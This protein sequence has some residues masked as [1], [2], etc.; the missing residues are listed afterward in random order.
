[1]KRT[2]LMTCISIIVL[3]CSMSCTRSKNRNTETSAKDNSAESSQAF[4]Y[5]NK[6]EE[7]RIS[8]ATTTG[9]GLSQGLLTNEQKMF[10]EQKILDQLKFAASLEKEIFKVILPE[11]QQRLSQFEVLSYALEQFLNVKSGQLVGYECQKLNLTQNG[12]Q[13]FSFKSFCFKEPKTLAEIVFQSGGNHSFTVRFFTKEWQSV[14][15][16][17]AQLVGGDRECVFK[18]E[19]KTIVR[20]TCDHTV[21]NIN[22]SSQ[23]VSLQDIRIKTFEYSRNDQQEVRL[24]GGLY[25]DMIEIKKIKLTIP[26]IGKIKYE[27]K[28]LKIKDDFAD[29]Q[30]KLLG[31]KTEQQQPPTQQQPQ[32]QQESVKHE[33]Q[34]EITVESPKANENEKTERKENSEQ[35]LDNSQTYEEK[36]TQNPNSG[37]IDSNSPTHER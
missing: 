1:M 4:D 18:I 37:V 28:K 10:K 21:F 3:F 6:T 31:E 5:T 33:N 19:N 15:G 22:Q 20:L 17:S 14:I 25:K 23:D 27:E 8:S 35:T 7:L 26:T 32:P 29:M 24:V 9:Q 36:P 12:Y 11:D 13:K 16:T 34:G 30:K 2:F